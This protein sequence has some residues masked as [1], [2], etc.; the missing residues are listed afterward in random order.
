MSEENPAED[1][2]YAV[3]N[4]VATITLNR[5][6]RRNAL[7]WNAYAQLE[8]ALKA[9]SADSEVRCVI[10][11]GADPAFCSGDDV[12]EI[13]AG[14]NA[15]AATRSALTIVKH[16]PTPAAMAALECEKPMI[17]AVNGAAIGWGMELA[18]YADI[19]IASEKAKFSEMF[20]KRGLVPDVGGFYRL[21]A[22]VGPAKAAELM[23][24]GDVIDA[25]EALRI[26]LV[27]EVTPHDD[28]LPRAQAL[29]A[30]I[31]ANP[32]LALRFIKEGLSRFSY[33]DP[34]EIGAWAIEA[35]RRL[36][37]TEDHKEGVASF[38]EKREPVFKGK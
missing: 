11:T 5:P 24:T 8:T 35:I 34:R 17:A 36:M 12:A 23:F 6:H 25:A 13:M 31:A 2:I 15:F 27:S 7:N 1:V 4:H 14:P 21:P 3:A 22:I 33:G 29:A 26:G 10:V 18:I 16:Q 38:L 9:A 19:R 28:L 30:R 32:P 20:I 37:E